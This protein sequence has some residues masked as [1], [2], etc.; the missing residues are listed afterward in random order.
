MI[1]DQ[2]AARKLIEVK[3]KKSLRPI[4]TLK[5]PSGLSRDFGRALHREDDQL[6]HVIAEV[7]KASPSKGVI[8]KDFDHVAIAKS[9]ETAG[10]AAISVLTDKEFFHGSLSYLTD[11]GSS[12]ALPVIRK[13]FIIDPYQIHEARAAGAD[14]VLLIA[15][16]LDTEQLRAFLGVARELGMCAL[17]EVHDEEEL[18][19]ALEANAG[20]IGINN[21]NLQTF[22][23]DLETTFRLIKSIPR[24]VLKVSES[25]ISSHADLVR[26]AEAGVDAVLVGESLMRAPDPGKKLKE[27]ILG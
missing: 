18:E 22:E 1:L 5:M 21:R 19:S 24:Y 2:I 13:D 11:C 17:V 16:L 6:P 8:R 12:V 7:K 15:A 27:L 23:V 10:A 4:E 26:L 9:Y 20:I 14:A 3:E 25:G